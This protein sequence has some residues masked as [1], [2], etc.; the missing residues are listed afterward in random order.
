MKAPKCLRGAPCRRTVF[1]VLSALV[2]VLAFLLGIGASA[3]KSALN[4]YVD[5]T[6]EGLYTLSDTFLEEVGDIEDEITVTF[7]ADPDTLLNNYTTRYVYV[8][9]REIERAMPN[10]TVEVY[11]VAQN[12]TAV[13]K[14]RTTSS[15]VISSDHVIVSCDGGKRYRILS[16]ASFW[17]TD[18]TTEEYFAYNGEYKMATA[19][20]SITAHERPAAYFTVG[21]GE[22]VY[23]PARPEDEE[24]ARYRAFYQLL[25]DEGLRVGMVNLDTEA[26]PEDC[27]L[28]IMNGPTAD[29]APGRDDWFS[30]NTTPALEKI[31]R[32][33]DGVGSLMVFKDPEVT[34]PALSEYLSEWGI[35]YADGAYLKEARGEGLDERE[36][37][38]LVATYPKSD[39]DA[40]GYSLF[41]D[42]AGLAAAPR[43]VVPH[44][45]YLLPTWD[46][47]T[48]M[49]SNNTSAM[50]SAVLYSSADCRAYDAA[51]ALV[52]DGGSYAL[53]RITARVYTDEVRDYYS[54]VFCAASTAMVESEQLEN[55][56]NANYDVMFSAVRTISR[57]DRYA[58]DALGGLNMNTET[59]G[60][61]RLHS[62][63]ISATDRPVYKNGK[64]V[65]TYYGLTPTAVVVYTVL[66]LAVPAAV[67]ALG[68]VRC[69]R[70]RH[71]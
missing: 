34:L 1:T 47:D 53:A 35:A 8:M 61:K 49:I 59:F 20:L 54:Y 45:G 7:C 52:D 51:G 48:K 63:E 65:R 38:R 60:G 22:R 66:I 36:R 46:G 31:D 11:N 56:T 64:V 12:P 39:K 37:E 32:Y 24:N 17:S 28:L 71:L 58:S 42:V 19:M 23:D 27:V 33:L 15:S 18:S 43:T 10:V 44:S 30:V 57:T 62:E 6:R 9:A 25:L 67:A 21:H 55:P 13:Q 4:S 2:L 40:L 5:L 50:T 14:Y 29:Y 69:V 41:G 3:V 68:I 16:A 70:R 26:I